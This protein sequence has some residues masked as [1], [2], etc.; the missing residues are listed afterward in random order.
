MGV[1]RPQVLTT[2]DCDVVVVGGGP[3]GLIAARDL[4]AEGFR[5]I[6]LE[7]HDTIGAPVHCTGVLGLDAIEELDLPRHTVLDVASSARFV[8]AD[9]TSIVIETDRI[10]AAIVDRA[11]FDRALADNAC[12][13]GATLSSNQRVRTIASEPNGVVVRTAASTV[14]ARACVL[15]C[16]AS[17]RFNR[18]LG[19][20]LVAHVHHA[21]VPL[22]VQMGESV[23]HGFPETSSSQASRVSNTDSR[24]GSLKISWRRPGKPR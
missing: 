16:G 8:S 11:K 21:S 10:R 19:L 5:T 24:C 1:E 23:A 17:Y 14:R 6:I 15:A 2:S 13:A 9:G 18:A 7:E 12:A 22:G 20:G 4:A 3:A